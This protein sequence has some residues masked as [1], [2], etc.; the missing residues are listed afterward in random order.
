M[1]SYMEKLRE[2]ITMILWVSLFV[3][4][5][6]RQTLTLWSYVTIFVCEKQLFVELTAWCWL[7]NKFCSFFKILQLLASNRATKKLC[8]WPKKFMP[9]HFIYA[10][11]L[12]LADKFTVLSF[13]EALE[14]S[15][16]KLSESEES[17]QDDKNLMSQSCNRSDS[18]DESK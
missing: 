4:E 7:Y 10:L 2:K 14:D 11:S 18:M 5:S 6:W 16:S 1:G 9:C 12:Y 8:I 3:Y 17:R 13:L 15:V